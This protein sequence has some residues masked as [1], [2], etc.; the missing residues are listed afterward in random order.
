MCNLETEVLENLICAVLFSFRFCFF[1]FLF[2]LSFFFLLKTT[3]ALSWLF[4]MC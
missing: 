3:A 4:V 2:S 1:F